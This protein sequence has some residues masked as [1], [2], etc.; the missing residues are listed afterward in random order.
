VSGPTIQSPGP[1][2]PDASPLA[3]PRVPSNV[4]PTV[5]APPDCFSCQELNNARRVA[6]GELPSFDSVPC[7]CIQHDDT[8]CPEC[9]NTGRPFAG[10][11][12]GATRFHDGCSACGREGS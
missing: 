2:P 3:A 9:D 1:I 5:P 12:G 4:G 6:M 7:S 11:Y 10:Y 8:D